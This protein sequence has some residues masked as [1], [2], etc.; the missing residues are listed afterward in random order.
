MDNQPAPQ[1]P[2]EPQQPEPYVPVSQ[3]TPEV[4]IA[5][6]EPVVPPAAAPAPVAPMPVQEAQ[7]APAQ[8]PAPV[9]EKTIYSYNST[10][11]A[12]SKKPLTIIISVVVVVLLIGGSVLG[13]MFGANASANSYKS[14]LTSQWKSDQNIFANTG[15]VSNVDDFAKDV[16]NFKDNV[17]KKPSLTALPLASTLSSSYKSMETLDKQVSAFYVKAVPYTE[18]ALSYFKLLDF[19]SKADDSATSGGGFSTAVK[20]MLGNTTQ[21]KANNQDIQRFI[22]SF[23]KDYQNLLNDFNANDQATYLTDY[24]TLSSDLTSQGKIVSDYFDSQGADLK[25]QL[26]DVNKQL[27]IKAITDTTQGTS[28]FAAPLSSKL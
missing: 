15:T 22:T 16:N 24:N 4:P 10:R 19:E 23:N 2:I 25:T 7:P 20:T 18:D 27:G 28:S 26:N 1:P 14:T 6:P 5:A 17:A 21:L 12:K 9:D 8:A 11:Q 3:P 13:L